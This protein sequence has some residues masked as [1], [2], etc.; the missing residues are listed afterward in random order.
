MGRRKKQPEIEPFESLGSSKF[1][2]RAG[3]MQTEVYARFFESMIQSDAFITLS[4][5]QKMLYMTCKF[6]FYGKRKPQEDYKDIP[7]FQGN[8]CFYL[9]K[10][11]L[12]EKYHIYSPTMDKEIYGN[13]KQNI[14]GD[15]KILEEHGLIDIIGA[16]RGFKQ[17]NIYRLSDRWKQWKSPP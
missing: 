3:E 5:R 6:Q 8:E 12:V 14:P 7:E 16:G 1:K 13:T 11:D 17:K 9:S 2:N 4:N 15:F 10:T